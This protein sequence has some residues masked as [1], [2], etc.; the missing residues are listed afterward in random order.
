MPPPREPFPE[1]NDD[2]E[3]EGS[4]F[5]IEKA[6]MFAGF[7]ARAM[8]RHSRLGPMLFVLV[9][10]VVLG[11]VALLPP[12]YEVDFR[13][14]AERNL[15]L[16][17]LGNPNRNVPR[18]ADNPMR[19]VQETLLQRDNLVSLVKQV[20]LI[21]RWDASR[22]PVLRYKDKL[23]T[24]IFGPT[25]EDDKI[26]AL[27]G[28]LEKKMWVQTEDATITIF[29]DWP[30]AQIAFEISSLVE[31]NFID[32]KYDTDVS[33]ISEAI[34]ILDE[35]AKEQAAQVDVALG[36]LTKLEE[37]KK[38]A[39]LGVAVTPTTAPTSTT[40]TGGGTSGGGAARPAPRAA[41]RQVATSANSEV[42]LQ[43]DEVR[44]KIRDMEDD[45]KRALGDAQR[46]LADARLTLGPLHPTVVS[47]N[48]KID[49]LEQPS[50]ELA[51]LKTQEHALVA[52]IAGASSAPAPAA[53]GDD[54]QP[55]TPSPGAARLPPRPAPAGAGLLSPTSS[56][57]PENTRDALVAALT[58]REDAATAL[59]RTK[60]QA[61]SSKYNELLTRIEAAHIELDVSKAAFKYKYRVSRPP[62][63]PK[64]P[65]KPNKP[66]IIM[67]GLVVAL[68]LALLT[69]GLIDLAGGR[70]LEPWQV[71]EALNMPVI[72]ELLPP[73][74]PRS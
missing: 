52:S 23:T 61:A 30:S 62:E 7:F 43:L 9:A 69:P 50:P 13:L 32:A 45:R 65:V 37:A 41:P 68:L 21:D 63:F 49:A 59:A 2:E 27:V 1:A 53:G 3:S 74:P 19:H 42:A 5:T 73:P 39:A 24:A 38:A 22:P 67:I 28:L 46:Q 71:Q 70:L 11:V 25:S 54:D 17:A 55:S 6:K 66:K 72:G 35:R 15:L 57:R 47:L 60:L 58:D 36:E 10:S 29:V 31:K 8:K 34:H 14:L 48:E 26:H 44:K 12:T 18:E 4:G 64:K 20:D 33:V 56:P 51:A 40:G 16:P